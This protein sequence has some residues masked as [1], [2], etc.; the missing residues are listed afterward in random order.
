[1]ALKVS[2]KSALSRLSSSSLPPLGAGGENP[3]LL[4]AK[5]KTPR[6]RFQPERLCDQRV[7][8]YARVGVERQVAGVDREVG[9][10]EGFYLL[11]I[12]PRKRNRRRPEHAVVRDEQIRPHVRRELHLPEPRVNGGGYRAHF[13]AVGALQAVFRAV[14]VFELPDAQAGVHKSRY[15]AEVGALFSLRVFH[16][17][18]G[19]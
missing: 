13:P 2:G 17:F 9:V 12:A 14:V 16:D 10:R 19:I 7:V 18:F 15:L 4:P 11:V 5:I 8:A 6:E 1:M 3:Y